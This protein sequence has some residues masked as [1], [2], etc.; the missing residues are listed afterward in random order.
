M[1]D[2]NELTFDEYLKRL[3]DAGN[4]LGFVVEKKD[5]LNYYNFGAT[6]QEVVET[7]K[8]VSTK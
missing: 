1:T 8:N 2:K 3:T 4:S 6:L 5:A 7:E